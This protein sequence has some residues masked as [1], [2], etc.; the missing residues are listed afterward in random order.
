[1]RVTDIYLWFICE[2]LASTRRFIRWWLPAWGR[3]NCWLGP[4]SQS[5][6]RLGGGLD[7]APGSPSLPREPPPCRRL[8]GCVPSP[9]LSQGV[10][11]SRLIPRLAS[12]L[13]WQLRWATPASQRA[14]S[15]CFSFDAE[16]SRISLCVVGAED[17]PAAS[18]G[19][20]NSL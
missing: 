15:F 3:R 1:M 18:R 9:W 10:H 19:F 13:V 20:S 4:C 6:R 12:L 14:F 16:I 11:T 2:T 17:L 5:R 8:P 7:H